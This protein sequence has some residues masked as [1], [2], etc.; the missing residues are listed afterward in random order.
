[1]RTNF[2]LVYTDSY[3]AC[4]RPGCPLPE[5]PQSEAAACYRV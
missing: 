4:G 5:G 2:R 3:G 1:M